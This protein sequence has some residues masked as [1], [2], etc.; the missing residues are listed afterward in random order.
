MRKEKYALFFYEM[1]W[2]FSLK[3]FHLLM[4]TYHNSSYTEVSEGGEK[5][6]K[7]KKR[8]NI[9]CFKQRPSQSVLRIK[10]IDL[11]GSM[12]R[13]KI[14]IKN[15]L[16]TTYS[17]WEDQLGD[18]SGHKHLNTHSFSSRSYRK[19]LNGRLPRTA[20]IMFWGA[21]HTPTKSY[22]RDFRHFPTSCEM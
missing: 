15:F 20:S 17:S 14:C 18:L 1:V 11:S 12:Q 3:K 4:A 21:H 19:V 13:L 5:K 16:T 6:K 10:R 7:K 2:Y 22:Q 9:M 8:V